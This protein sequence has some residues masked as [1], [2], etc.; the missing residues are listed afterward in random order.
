M[1]KRMEERIRKKLTAALQPTLL[2]II[3]DSARHEGH[4]GA[5]P[6]GSTHFKI[7][8][9][10][11]AFVG[12]TPVAQHRLVYEALAEEMKNGIHALVIKASTPNKNN[13]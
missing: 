5:K 9:T 6:G 7:A 4:V 11:A 3:D 1:R 2:E 13:L 8:I 10:S 12:L